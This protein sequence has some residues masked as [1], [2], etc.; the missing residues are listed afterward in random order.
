MG[1]AVLAA[2]A[3]AGSA[4]DHPS[5]VAERDLGSKVLDWWG[6][7]RSLPGGPWLFSRLIGRLVPYSG[8]IGARVREL[9]PGFARLTLRDRRPVRQHLRSVHAVALVN[10]GELTSGLALV[11]ALPD[12]VRA[13]VLSLSAEYFRKARGTLT[14]E[15]VVAPP[16]ITGPTE[17][18]VEA[19]IRDAEGIVVCRVRVVWRLD[20]ELGIGAHG[21]L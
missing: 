20:R 9:R 21:S 17:F 4:T 14:A 3:G 6:R 10:L 11:T 1:E 8:S 2:G 19:E 5:R 12:H 16:E 18:P 15:A 7:L 13:I